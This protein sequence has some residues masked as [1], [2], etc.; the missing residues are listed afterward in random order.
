MDEHLA[1]LSNSAM[2][3]IWSLTWSIAGFFNTLLPLQKLSNL[4]TILSKNKK[5]SG[6]Q[7]LSRNFVTS[8]KIS[9]QITITTRQDFCYF[10]QLKNCRKLYINILKICPTMEDWN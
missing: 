6:Y 5:E 7:A 10:N 3:A 2:S 4:S 1:T 9:S 8:F